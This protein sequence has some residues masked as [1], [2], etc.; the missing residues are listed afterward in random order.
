MA[1]PDP[2]ESEILKASSCPTSPTRRVGCCTGPGLAPPLL[3]VDVPPPHA[4]TAA[5][6]PM[7]T[8]N[9]AARG[10]FTL[11]PYHRAV[12]TRVTRSGHG[13]HPH[14]ARARRRVRFK[15]ACDACAMAPTEPLVWVDC[16]MTGLD[17]VRDVL[18]EIA[19]VVTDS[20]LTLLDAGLDL[21]IATDPAKLEAMD[22]V[23]REMHTQ[24]GLLEAL[25]TA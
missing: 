10:C 14:S 25:R 18:V 20:D 19:V 6:A 17:P 8:A 23:V 24:S 3:P 16:E 1:C 2:S 12:R 7:A 15:P 13:R 9:L 11:P 5:A 22:D 4:A 21:L